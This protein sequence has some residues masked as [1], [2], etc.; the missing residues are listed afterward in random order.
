MTGLLTFLILMLLGQLVTVGLLVGW[1]R[2]KE[3]ETERQYEI[4]L[5]EIREML[6]TK[7]EREL[8]D[9]RREN[10]PRDDAGPSAKVRPAFSR[11]PPL[12]P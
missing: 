6:L 9:A 2:A 11:V 5:Q 12:K 3:R 4:R 10:M 1:F 8:H 7:R